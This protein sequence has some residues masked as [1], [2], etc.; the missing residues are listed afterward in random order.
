MYADDYD[1]DV[2]AQ[3][4]VSRPSTPAFACVEEQYRKAKARL[5]A[6]QQEKIEAAPE[7]LAARAAL[8]RWMEAIWPGWGG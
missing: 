7:F 2:S 4:P 3:V 8:S 6:A 1:P 5:S